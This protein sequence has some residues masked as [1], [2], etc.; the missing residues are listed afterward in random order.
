MMIFIYYNMPMTILIHYNMPTHLR[1]VGNNLIDDGGLEVSI[2]RPHD[3]P[4]KL[5]SQTVTLVHVDYKL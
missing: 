5:R 3:G 1:N 2:G 4:H